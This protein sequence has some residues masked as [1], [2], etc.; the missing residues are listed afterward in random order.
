MPATLITPEM[1]PAPGG[2]E[3]APAP[4]AGQRRKAKLKWAVKALV[5]AGVLALLF[6]QV[7]LGGVWAAMRDASPGWLFG[8]F[9]LAML[10]QVAV[11]D[12]LR[13]L[14]AAQ[15]VALS[16]FEVFEIN[17]A[18]LF[19]GLFLPGGNFT[20]IAIRF[21][22]LGSA[23]QSLLNTGVALFLDRVVATVTLLL[24]GV[25]FWL[26][27]RPEGTAAALWAMLAA[28]G[29]LTMLL[30]AVF[31]PAGVPVLGTFQ[32]ALR[33][34]GGAKLG[35]V[36]DAMQSQWELPRPVLA[37]VFVLSTLSHLLGIA[38][39]WAIAHAMGLDLSFVTVG[40]VRSAMILATM[41]PVTPSGVGL[42]EGA[43]VALFAGYGLPGE[44]AVAFS[45]IVFGVTVLAVGAVGG[46]FEARR[47]GVRD[48]SR[49]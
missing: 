45:L 41:I 1:L 9:A 26:L 2:V 15:G 31:A 8:A 40:W 47:L 11:A 43:A 28:A 39:Y 35:R 18:T 33:R 30:V 4:S 29:G 3:A 49:R 36:A 14:I 22:R 48:E 17:L 37:L 25:G 34:V 38:A 44:D 21:Y 6:T 20:G 13:R 27:E 5:A 12:R 24:V 32:R 46:L 23:N 19:Y 42:R 10:L 7:D 16:T